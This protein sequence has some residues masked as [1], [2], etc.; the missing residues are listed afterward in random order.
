MQQGR[1]RILL[2]G[3][4]GAVG[5]EVLKTLLTNP[6][7]SQLTLLGRRPVKGVTDARV[8]Q[9][10][11]DIFRPDEYQALL[12]NYDTAVCCLGVG[13]PSKV[14]KEDF[15]KIDKQAVF[16]FAMRCHEAGVAHFELLSSVGADAASSYFYLQAKGALIDNIQHLGFARFSAFQPSMI[17]TPTNRYGFSQGVLLKVWPLLKPLL[18]GGLKKYR[19]V[20]VE[21]LGAAIANNI[22]REGKGLEILQWTDFEQLTD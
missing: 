18:F 16:D 8:V 17:L 14:S 3:A 21:T 15:L 7:V 6:L 19:G 12:N 5:G 4:T 22:F 13:Q 1:Q 11:I 20:R 9:H 10:Q 2:L